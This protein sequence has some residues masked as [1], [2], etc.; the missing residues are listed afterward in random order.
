M[1]HHRENHIKLTLTLTLPLIETKKWLF[2]LKQSKLK[3]NRNPT[4]ASAKDKLR[5]LTCQCKFRSFSRAIKEEI[6]P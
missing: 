6:K 3:E 5:A 2:I 4:V 1:Y